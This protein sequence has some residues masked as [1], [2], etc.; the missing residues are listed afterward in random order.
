MSSPEV[1]INYM[2]ICILNGIK[3]VAKCTICHSSMLKSLKIKIS[4]NCLMI[5]VQNMY[6]MEICSKYLVQI[7]FMPFT[8]I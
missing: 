1:C 4:H 2:N 6:Y 7:Q 8:L 3:Y 5:T